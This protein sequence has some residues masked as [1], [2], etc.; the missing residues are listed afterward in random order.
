MENE[1]G[2]FAQS[3][4]EKWV[5]M[6]SDDL[7]RWALS[8]TNEKETAEDIVQDTFIAAFKSLDKFQGKS[9]AKTWL[10]SILNNKIMDYHRKK[11]RSITINESNVNHGINND[12]L[13]DIFDGQDSWKDEAKPNNWHD[14]DGHLLDN[15]EFNETLGSC[16]KELPGNWFSAIQFKYIQDK[17]AK[18]ICQELDIKPSNYWQILHRAK[19]QLRLCL[20]KNWIKS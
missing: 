5:V 10:F 2:T 12:V 8:K 11:F 7:Y 13:T 17:S 3:I 16:M 19:L 1:Q 9:Q 6:Y 4:I 18:E 14:L 20:E 15:L